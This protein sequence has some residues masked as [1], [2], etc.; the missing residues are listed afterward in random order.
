MSDFRERLREELEELDEKIEKLK[1]FVEDKE[2]VFQTLPAL[3]RQ[4]M[5][6]QL[7]TMSNYG[8]LLATRISLIDSKTEEPKE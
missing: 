4:L 3:D 6:I 7:T 5:F 1:T 2:G 8:A